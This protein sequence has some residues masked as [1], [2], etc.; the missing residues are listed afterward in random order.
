MGNPIQAVC[1]SFFKS[2]NETEIKQNLTNKWLQIIQQS[3]GVR[4]QSFV[5]TN[6]KEWD[7]R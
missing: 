7:K 1:K 3:E 6:E 2:E 4:S 5:S